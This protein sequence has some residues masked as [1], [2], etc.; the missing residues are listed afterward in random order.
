VLVALLLGVIGWGG[1]RGWQWWQARRE[2][3][4]AEAALAQRRFPEARAHLDAYLAIWPNSAAGHFLAARTAWRQADYDGAEE[5]LARSQQLGWDPDVVKLER[6]LLHAHQGDIPPDVEK[7]LIRLSKPE[8]NYPDA[9]IIFEALAKGYLRTYRMSSAMGCLNAWLEREPDNPEALVWRGWMR[10]EQDNKPLALEDYAHAV[11]VDPDND[12]A[13]LRLCELLALLKQPREEEEHLRRLSERLP[14]QPI[15]LFAWASF[16]RGEGRTDEAIKALDQL[17]ADPRLL[18]VVRYRRGGDGRSLARLH[19]ETQAWVDKVAELASPEN[20][21]PEYPVHLYTNAVELRA[22]LALSRQEADRAETW[23][24]DVLKISPSDLQAHFLLARSLDKQ[25]KREEAAQH[26]AIW[27]AL[28]KKLKRLDEVG[29]ELGRSPRDSALRSEA[30][31]LHFELG[32]EGE[33]LRWL[34][35]IVRDDAQFALPEPTLRELK[36]YS[37]RSHDLRARGLLE[38]FRAGS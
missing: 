26:R 16:Y 7:Q 15:V 12:Q 21:N 28:E 17:I 6:R 2:W 24:R 4:A 8:L 27:Q 31:Q 22:E 29:K 30:A 13:R 35:S 10:A 20:R 25:G 5:H 1:Y 37:E 19:P 36:A 38:A 9:P 3:Q 32:N 11:R 23:L 18:E 34:E 14:D 33:A